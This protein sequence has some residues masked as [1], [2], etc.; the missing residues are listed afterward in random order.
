[1]ATRSVS[2]T[3]DLSRDN[4]R[5]IRLVALIELC[6]DH[7]A[8]KV[9]IESHKSFKQNRRKKRQLI[10]NAEDRAKENRQCQTRRK[11]TEVLY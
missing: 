3:A 6:T 4:S 11:P 5:L 1:M 2:L 8:R 7:F 10:F 9:I